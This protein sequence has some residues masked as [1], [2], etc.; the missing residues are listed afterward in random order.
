MPQAIAAAAVALSTQATVAALSVGASVGAA[1]VV[2]LATY[3]AV[4]VGIYAVLSL[5]LNA[6]F[7]PKIPGQEV[8]TPLKQPIPVRRSGYGR[9]RLS[10]YY[11]LFEA[12]DTASETIDGDTEKG[13]GA[14]FDVLALHDGRIDG[15]ETYYLHDDIVTLDGVGRVQPPTGT[16]K[17]ASRILIDTRD[18]LTTETAYARSSTYLSDLWSTAHRG[19]GIASLEM[20]CWQSKP[21]NQSKDYPNG[22]PQPSVAARLLRV[23]DPRLNGLYTQGE[24][25]N[26]VWSD[27]PILHLLDYLT[28][29]SHGMG[30]DFASYIVPEIAAW[31][32]AANV[33]EEQ[34]RVEYGV[35]EN[36]YRSGGVFDHTTNPADVIGQILSTC[37]GWL[38]QTPNGALTVLAGKYYEPTVTLTDDHVLGYTVQH[39][40]ADENAVNELRPTFTSADNLYAE[41]DAGA[42]RDE[43]DISERGKVLSQTMPL[44]WCPSATQSL[45]LAKRQMT[46]Q[47]AGLRGTLKTN[48]YGMNA[49][50]ER[51]L[52]LQISEN[53][54]L[55]N[56]PVEVAKIEVD[57]ASLTV[58]IDWVE[59][60]TEVDEWTTAEQEAA[61]AIIPAPPTRTDAAVALVAPTITA[62][63]PVYT[64]GTGDGTGT[65]LSVDITA[66]SEF[67]VE[68]LLRWREQGTTDWT[69][70]KFTDIDD[71]ASVTLI[72]G[73]VLATGNIELQA[74]YQTAGATSDWSA[75]F[76]VAVA[77][78]SALSATGT[79]AATLAAN[80][81]V[82]FYSGGV[83][84]ADAS[85]GIPAHGFVSAAVSF[86][87][88][89]TVHFSGQMTGLS[90]LTK[91]PVYLSTTA[92]ALTN[93]VPSGSG[94]IVQQV[95]EATSATT[96]DFEAQL[97]ITLR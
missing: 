71:G 12:R 78:P 80:D 35:Y 75:T 25:G 7:A 53:R 1:S 8:Q 19:D 89:A 42:W 16:R 45:R 43:S 15:I 30:L 63:T 47:S 13:G 4:E 91:G 2:G 93:T 96:V 24:P 92:G 17:Y 10:G 61:Q 82:N 37:D 60:D 54:D 74:A 77:A 64:P 9:A 50:G 32:R 88:T 49:L 67:D 65:R 48:L 81:L 40:L 38:A 83:R 57:P 44:P 70:G 6:A 90:G 55:H 39:F 69:E 72:S 26:W 51:Y 33:C 27:N 18:G 21:L 29:A 85:A 87:A 58:S 22:L 56:L 14:S 36:R 76:T 28:S 3:A 34:V 41:N 66:P 86:G 79:A 95:G 97:E 52:R 46:R 20:I 23:Y 94:Q 59:A 31:A 73:F 5:A 11:M 84:K 68:W 62:A